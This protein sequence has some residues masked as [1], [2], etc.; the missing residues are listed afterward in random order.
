M[1]HMRLRAGVGCAAVLLLAL[2][3]CAP[4]E[5]VPTPTPSATTAES[6]SPT[7]TAD[8]LVLTDCET[9]LPL[10]LAKS[11][12]SE[13]TEFFGEYPAAEFAGW[14]S[15]PEIATTID[16]ASQARLC[17]WGVPNSDGQFALVVAEIPPEGRATMMGALTRA[18]FVSSTVG[19][20][21]TAELE[22]EGVVS[23]EAATH[24]FT[25]G[26][27]ILC[28]GTTTLDLTDGVTESALDALRAANPTLGL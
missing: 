6:P 8:P 25:G 18:G 1:L 21:T 17:R 13:D 23:L 20:V 27:W 14:V 10:D 11:L 22:Q 4:P 3:G 7:S 15:V 12:F 5:Q 24:L 19:P 16:A 9:M 28:D 2:S 26:L